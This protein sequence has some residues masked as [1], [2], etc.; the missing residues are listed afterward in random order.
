MVTEPFG[1]QMI[2]S[3]FKNLNAS[4]GIQ[5]DPRDSFTPDQATYSGHV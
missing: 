1:I 5:N 3:M 4:Q 2:S